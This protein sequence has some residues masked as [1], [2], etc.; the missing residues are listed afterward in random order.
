VPHLTIDSAACR[1][2]PRSSRSSTCHPRCVAASCGTSVRIL[3]D[4]LRVTL[5]NDGQP[6]VIAWYVAD[7]GTWLAQLRERTTATP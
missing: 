5:D 3:G 7:L 2:P 6:D 1:Q 4:L